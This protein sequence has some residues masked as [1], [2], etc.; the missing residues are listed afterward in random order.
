MNENARPEGRAQFVP[1]S[2]LDNPANST[3]CAS[4]AT[5]KIFRVCVYCGKRRSTPGR[6]KAICKKCQKKREGFRRVQCERMRVLRLDPIFRET[7]RLAL[8]L[9]MRRLRAKRR[10]AVAQ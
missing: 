8:K 9:R 10:L 2:D 4:P 3:N 1:S 5:R 6:S 7:E